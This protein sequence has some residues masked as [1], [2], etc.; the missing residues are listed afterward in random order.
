M[1]KTVFQTEY[2]IEI[3]FRHQERVSFQFDASENNKNVSK[4]LRYIL[5]KNK[6]NYSDKCNFFRKLV[7]L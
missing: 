4:P 1:V 6:H 3:I 5:Y 2:N 7:Y